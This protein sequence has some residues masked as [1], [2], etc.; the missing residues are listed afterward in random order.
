[1]YDRDECSLNLLEEGS[2]EGLTMELDLH[3]RVT[4]KDPFD[5]YK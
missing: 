1:M 2:T 5:L 3:A 4:C